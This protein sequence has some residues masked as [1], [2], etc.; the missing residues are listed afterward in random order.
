MKVVLPKSNGSGRKPPIMSLVD[1]ESTYE[2]TKANSVAWDLRTVP[3]D[4]DS[5]TYRKQVR[6]LSGDEPIRTKSCT[7]SRNGEPPGGAKIPQRPEIRT[8][9]PQTASLSGQRGAKGG[10][11]GQSGQCRVEGMLGRT[12]PN[13]VPHR[14]PHKGAP[15]RGQNPPKA[16]NSHTKAPNCLSERTTGGQGR[17]GGPER[18]VQG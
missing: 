15:R 14:E 10:M 18:A 3:A 1:D 6:V 9:R 16:R 12:H 13:K 4:Q 17:D 2:L 8:R 7:V 11:E 5:S